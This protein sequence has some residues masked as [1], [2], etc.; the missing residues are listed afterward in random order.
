M[1]VKL[2][3]RSRRPVGPR[4]RVRTTFVDVVPRELGHELVREAPSLSFEQRLAMAVDLA[5][6]GR[7]RADSWSSVVS[8]EVV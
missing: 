1:L 8:A 6:S 3:V 2:Q 4:S 5:E 7:A